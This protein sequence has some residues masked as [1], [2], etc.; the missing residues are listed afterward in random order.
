M[1]SPRPE[2]IIK[3]VLQIP[4]NKSVVYEHS[5]AVT[6]DLAKDPLALGNLLVQTIAGIQHRV[7]KAEK[8][9]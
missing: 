1:R 9:Q 4:I 3:I 7:W 2:G 6:V 8:D 5:I